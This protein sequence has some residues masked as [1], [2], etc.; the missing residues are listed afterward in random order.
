MKAK[1]SLVPLWLLCW[2]LLPATANEAQTVTQI[3]AGGDNSLFLKSDGSLWGM[4]YNDYGQLGDG[5]YN[6]TNCPEQIVASNV[7]AIAAGA[8]HSLFL[9]SDGSLW[10]MGYNGNGE[11]GNGT[12]NSMTN[13]PQQI[14]ASNVKAIAAGDGHSL[15]LKSNGSLWAMGFNSSGQLGDGTYNNANLPQQIVASNVTAIA[16]GQSFSLFLKSDGSLWAMGQNNSGELG[17]GTYNNANLPQQIVASNVTA[18]AAGWGHSLFV[19]NDGSLWAVGSDEYGQLGDGTSGTYDYTNRPQQIVASNVTA[20]GAGEFHS[21]FVKSDGSLWGMGNDYQGELGDGTYMTV[22]PYCTNQP[23]QILSSNVVAVA[24][25]Q[26]HSLLLKNDGSLWATGYNGFGQLGDGTTGNTN[27]PEQIVAGVPAGYN[28]ISCQ[29]LGGGCVC[30][31]FV[32][33][34]GTNYALDHSVSLS[35]ANWG[36]Q[37][38]NPAGAG[39]MVLFTNTPD[40][41]TI[42]FWRIRSVP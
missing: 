12:Y 21:L 31:S 3:A 28:Q 29:L 2:V 1:R 38:T 24:A 36:P 11:L 40:P 35:P 5:T 42:N 19:K 37:F 22:T 6:Q 20:I 7:T 9:K 15:F 8:I 10:G 34:A 13:R 30:L 16:A 32:G 17:D 26:F 33:M 25:G 39:G 41:T 18:I 23:E 4:G 27:R 14:V